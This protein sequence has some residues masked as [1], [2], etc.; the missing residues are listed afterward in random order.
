MIRAYYQI[1]IV[2]TH[3]VHSKPYM[4][5]GLIGSTNKEQQHVL[6]PDLVTLKSYQIGSVLD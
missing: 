1:M 4:I 6:N 3:K 5:A 2:K